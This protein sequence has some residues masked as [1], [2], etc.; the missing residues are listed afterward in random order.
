MRV[1]LII[2]T[3]VCLSIVIDSFI[4]NSRKHSFKYRKTQFCS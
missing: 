3:V 2:V 1:V 4:R